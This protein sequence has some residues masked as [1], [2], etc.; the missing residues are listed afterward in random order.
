MAKFLVEIQKQHREV[1]AVEDATAAEAQKTWADN[2]D[3][4]SQEL[5]GWKFYSVRVEA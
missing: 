4:V 1:Y 3:L 5:E 2:G